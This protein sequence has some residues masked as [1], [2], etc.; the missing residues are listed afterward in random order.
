MYSW[1]NYLYISSNDL[2]RNIIR[3]N[4]YKYQVTRWNNMNNFKSNISSIYRRKGSKHNLDTM[5]TYLTSIFF[6]LNTILRIL[7]RLITLFIIKYVIFIA[8]FTSLIPIAQIAVL[9]RTVLLLKSSDL[10]LMVLF[11]LKFLSILDW[12]I[13]LLLI[14]KIVLLIFVLSITNNCTKWLSLVGLIWNWF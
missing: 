12:K 10:Y 14:I 2:Q 8:L 3:A 1:G 9:D 4:K 11:F 7:V 6:S 5:I 13:I